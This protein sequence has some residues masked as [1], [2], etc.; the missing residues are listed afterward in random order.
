M[1]DQPA[2]TSP[3]AVDR[4]RSQLLELHE[5]L[6]DEMRSRW[7]RSLPWPELLGD[8][9]E[10]ARQLGFGEGASIYDSSV[11]IGDV[12][13]GRQT[14]IGP[15]TVLD[16]S[17]TLSI[18]EYCSISSGVQIY[19]HDTVEWAL[20]RGRSGPERAPVSIG[21]CCYIG[22]QSVIGKGIAIGSH[23]VVGACSFVNRSIPERSIAV[24]IPC[25]LIGHVEIDDQGEVRLVYDD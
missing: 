8:R 7:N 3:D 1:T 16:G 14:W 12:T 5:R 2:S 6:A 18:G 11:V 25:R 13:V 19:T 24:G 17:G 22:S 4:L 23:S 20:S 21:D 9:W 10:R 15:Y